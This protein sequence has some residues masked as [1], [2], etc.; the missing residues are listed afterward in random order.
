MLLYDFDAHAEFFH[1]QAG[2]RGRVLGVD[3]MEVFV[4]QV[5][6]QFDRQTLAEKKPEHFEEKHQHPG[7]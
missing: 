3:C 1:T 2:R 6:N 7:K 4:A 5:Y